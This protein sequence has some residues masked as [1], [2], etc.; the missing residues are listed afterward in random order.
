MLGILRAGVAVASSLIVAVPVFVAGS[1]PARAEVAASEVLTWCGGANQS[2][3]LG[4]INAFRC[5]N[6]LQGA[7]DMIRALST[8]DLD[9]CLDGGQSAGTQLMARFIPDLKARAS[10][11]DVDATPMP[12]H[13]ADWLAGACNT[14]LA[15]A[16]DVAEPDSTQEL[17]AALLE[18]QN[19]AADYAE[20][21]ADLQ[22]AL[23]IAVTGDSEELAAC[24]ATIADLNQELATAEAQAADFGMQVAE[25]GLELEAT[26]FEATARRQEIMEA[27]E[28]LASLAEELEAAIAEKLAAENALDEAMDEVQR[29]AAAAE[30]G[31]TQSADIEQVVVTAAQRV[32]AMETE[33]AES[34]ARTADLQQQLAESEALHSQLLSDLSQA[35][36]TSSYQLDRIAE[37]E[38]TLESCRV[39]VASADTPT[40][41]VP[42][43]TPSRTPPAPPPAS[44]P[45]VVTSPGLIA[46]TP[47]NNSSITRAVPRQ[48]DAVGIQS[49]RQMQQ[50]ALRQGAIGQR[51]SWSTPDG[52]YTGYVMVLSEGY[53]SPSEFCREIYSEALNSGA[54]VHQGTDIYCQ[55]ANNLWVYVQPS[56]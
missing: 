36:A 14:E 2:G 37:L 54:V 47:P 13:I 38:Q 15:L 53:R 4:A 41:P 55:R 12:R 31:A 10:E 49:L 25:L 51:R 8:T 20:Q 30:E 5:V 35:S 18:A 50:A 56:G 24:T 21:V 6:Y 44:T 19:D 32:A 23:E 40:S 46:T 28:R 34:V 52:R 39:T 33:L 11:E 42:P 45:N 26:N 29:L 27:E 17:E 1:S 48:L 22:A 9:A 7:A 16:A 3:Q 43:Q